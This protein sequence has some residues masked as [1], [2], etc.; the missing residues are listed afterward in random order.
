MSS[1]ASNVSESGIYTILG[2]GGII[3]KELTSVLL[4]NGKQVRLVSR[5]V[6]AVDGASVMAA[7]ITDP[8]QTRRAISGSSVVF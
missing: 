3:A 7:D 1:T 6:Q 4:E 8:L 5:K 2:A